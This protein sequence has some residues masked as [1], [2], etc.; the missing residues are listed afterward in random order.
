MR[1]RS[2]EF[3]G[4][5]KTDISLSSNHLITSLV[6]CA[7]VT[8]SSECPKMAASDHSTLGLVTT[9]DWP[10]T[11]WNVLLSENFLPLL[12]PPM[13]T[14]FSEIQSLFHYFVDQVIFWLHAYRG[15]PSLFFVD[16]GLSRL[17][18][19]PKG[20]GASSLNMQP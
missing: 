6:L 19:S 18:P 20:L 10:L 2:E 9:F 5:C 4:Y 7:G 1:L 16:F 15:G 3:C 14:I 12:K 13:L 11:S 17:K 8:S